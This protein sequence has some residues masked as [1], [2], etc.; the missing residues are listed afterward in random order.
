MYR[1][2]VQSLAQTT[3]W[4]TVVGQSGGALTENVMPRSDLSLPSRVLTYMHG[5]SGV[6]I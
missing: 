3:L 1:F 2:S 4:C 6:S 5:T